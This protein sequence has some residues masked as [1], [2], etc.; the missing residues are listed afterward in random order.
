MAAGHSQLLPGPSPGGRA[1]Q[2][3]QL[4][5]PPEK[6]LAVLREGSGRRRWS[7]DS[8]PEVDTVW[9]PSGAFGSGDA[10]GARARFSLPSLYVLF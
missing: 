8:A 10:C 5:F 9:C 6:L 3:R 2:A 1:K 7:G 4:L